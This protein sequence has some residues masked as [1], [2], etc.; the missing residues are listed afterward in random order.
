MTR[1]RTVAAS[2]AAVLTLGTLGTVTACS[3]DDS[4]AEPTFTGNTDV[5]E[6]VT[7]ETSATSATSAAATTSEQETP[8][9]HIAVSA[10]G[11]GPIALTTGD[12]PEGES[13][14]VSGR[15]IVGP[16]SCFALKKPDGRGNEDENAPRPLVLPVDSEFVTRGDHPSV[17]LPGRDTVYVGETMDVEAVSMP[18][19]EL[20]GLPDPCARGAAES[21]LV[22]N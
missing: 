8:E 9:G 22:V 13:Q 5:A 17:T 18:F 4:T 15:L 11:G 16:G 20:D 2:L 14:K 7:T 19:N 10:S 3:D 1:H 21:G 6:T 12:T